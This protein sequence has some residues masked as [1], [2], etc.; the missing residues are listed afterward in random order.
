MFPGFPAASSFGWQ[1]ELCYEG[2]E[3]TRIQRL[4]SSRDAAVQQFSAP[5]KAGKVL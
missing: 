4:A 2:E 3:R 5:L 1:V